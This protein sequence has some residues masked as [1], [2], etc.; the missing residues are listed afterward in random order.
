MPFIFSCLGVYRKGYFKL[1]GVTGFPEHP[2]EYA[3]CMVSIPLTFRA[4]FRRGVCGRRPLTAGMF[5]L[6][7]ATLKK[8]DLI[9]YMFLTNADFAPKLKLYRNNKIFHAV[10][11]KD[12]LFLSRIDGFYQ[13]LRQYDVFVHAVFRFCIPLLSHHFIGYS[14]TAIVSAAVIIANFS[15]Q[16]VGDA[17]KTVLSVDGEIKNQHLFHR[18]I[19]H[20]WRLV[21][22]KVCIYNLAALI[23]SFIITILITVFFP[24][25]S[26]ADDLLVYCVFMFGFLYSLVQI[27]STALYPK[28]NWEHMY[29][30]GEAGK[31]KTYNNLYGS[32]I[33]IV[34][35]QISAITS[36]FIYKKPELETMLIHSASGILSCSHY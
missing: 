4:R 31:A 2:H 35:L 33:F 30:I 10:F 17:L 7:S 36:Y 21:F 32:F 13:E 25:S 5:K 1:Y 28:K 12:L 8:M 20:A 9:P 15:Y 16:L 26:R 22:P 29:E 6:W 3:V 14:A 23:Y 34:S 24:S 18:N 19:K 27:S 11:Q